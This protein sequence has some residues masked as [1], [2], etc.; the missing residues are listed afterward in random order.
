MKEKA[1]VLLKVR[2][3]DGLTPGTIRIKGR[4]PKDDV[5]AVERAVALTNRHCRLPRVVPHRCEAIRFRIKAGDPGTRGLRSVRIKEREIGLQKLA[6]LNHVLRARR[7]GHD[8]LPS[9]RE[10]RLHDIPLADELREQ[11]LTGPHRIRRLVLIVGLL[12][13]RSSGDEQNRYSP[14][15]HGCHDTPRLPWAINFEVQKPS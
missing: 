15:R 6:V 9:H 14:F 4:G 13:Y 12:G 11:L 3:R 10:E 5:L 2:A 1:A 7:L 8:R